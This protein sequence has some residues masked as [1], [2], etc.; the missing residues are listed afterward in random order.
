MANTKI[1]IEKYRSIS[2]SPRILY[3]EKVQH[4]SP[5]KTVRS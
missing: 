1:R 3:F 5:G 2:H 4:D